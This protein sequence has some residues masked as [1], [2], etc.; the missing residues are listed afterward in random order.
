MQFVISSSIP[1][2]ERERNLADSPEECCTRPDSR[3]V[4][5]HNVFIWPI[6]RLLKP[7][8]ISLFLTAIGMCQL[9][10]F[11]HTSELQFLCL[12][13]VSCERNITHSTCS[14]ARYMG[15]LCSNYVRHM[16]RQ[17]KG[18]VWSGI[19]NVFAS[20]APEA[21]FALENSPSPPS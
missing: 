3:H 10:F 12:M 14:Y 17:G 13:N 11:F 7:K 20:E 1:K 19:R 5:F 9:C 8:H 21:L 2:G 16:Y 18:H 6:V 4:K 15:A